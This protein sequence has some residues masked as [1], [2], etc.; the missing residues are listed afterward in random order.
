MLG[1]TRVGDVVQVDAVDD[2]AA[3]IDVVETRQAVEHRRLA[4]AGRAHHDQ[5]LAPPDH[6]VDATQGLHLDRA[7]A[8]RLPHAIGD[9]DRPGWVSRRVGR[10]VRN[11]RRHAR[12]RYPR[13]RV[14][15]EGNVRRKQ[16]PPL[17]AAS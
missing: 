11:G 16:A 9:E 6:D 3:L 17:T 2:H 5:E 4:V 15:G 1:A 8:V 14:G 10:G 13:S 7:R 12:R